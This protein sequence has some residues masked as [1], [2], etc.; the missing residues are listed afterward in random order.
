MR[1]FATIIK[2]MKN[3]FIFAIFTVFS[4]P[5]ISWACWKITGFISD[6]LKQ[7][8]INQKII[9]NKTYSTQ[10]GRKIINFRIPNSK[11]LRFEYEIMEK[12]DHTI[13]SIVKSKVP[14]LINEEKI[15]SLSP[16]INAKL[17]LVEI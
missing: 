15:F 16:T 10:L 9:H 5:H 4:M 12:T 1:F 14:L 2:I 3:L 13:K 6:D 7:V 17:N 8:E 11:Q